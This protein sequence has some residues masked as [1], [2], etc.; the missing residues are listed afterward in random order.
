MAD[1]PAPPW[2]AVWIVEAT[3]PQRLI[4]HFAYCMC[5]LAYCGF[6]LQVHCLSV[7]QDLHLTDDAAILDL[8]QYDDVLANTWVDALQAFGAHFIAHIR[9][10]GHLRVPESEGDSIL[11]PFPD[12]SPDS[13]ASR[14]S[15]SQLD[16]LECKAKD[17]TSSKCSYSAMKSTELQLAAT[18]IVADS[19]C[20]LENVIFWIDK[21]CI[22]QQHSLKGFCIS[23][24]EEFLDRCDGMV[25]L[26][27]WEYFQRLWCVHGWAASFVRHPLENIAICMGAQHY[28]SEANFEALA[29]CSAIALIVREPLPHG[30]GPERPGRDAR[31]RAG[32]VDAALLSTPSEWLAGAAQGIQEASEFLGSRDG[33]GGA[34]APGRE[35]APAARSAATGA[36]GAAATTTKSAAEVEQDQL[37]VTTNSSDDTI[38]LGVALL[39]NVLVTAAI[40]LAVCC[41]WRAYPL[42]YSHR[43][44]EVQAL[45][46]PQDS[47]GG[48]FWASFSVTM[49]QATD[50]AG[51][52]VAMFVELCNFGMYLTAALG[53]PICVV[54]CPVYCYYGGLDSEDTLTRYSMNNIER[55]SSL[56]GFVALLVWVVVVVVHRMIWTAQEKFI[57]RRIAW[58]KA[59][60]EPRATTL[61][62]TD[63]PRQYC[64]DTGLKEYYE[65]LFPG[66]VQRVYVAKKIG[67][68]VSRAEELKSADQCLHQ[69]VHEWDKSGRRPDNRPRMLEPLSNRWTDKID[70]YTHAKVEAD[71]RLQTERDRV[72]KSMDGGDQ[73]LFASEGFV[74]FKTRRDA[75]IARQLQLEHEGQRFQ[76]SYAPDPDD[77][78]YTDLLLDSQQQR[79]LTTIG[80]GCIGF[81]YSSHFCQWSPPWHQS[82]I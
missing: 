26:L 75:E 23:M 17:V 38:K 65:K 39:F 15:V 19:G 70:F 50:V 43:S 18:E 34:G 78:R 58:L 13:A 49:E 60:P 40:L 14:A 1:A 74:T 55:D 59:M 79:V 57:P 42:V 11:D 72:Q 25:A 24:I 63:I 61:L 69:A 47:L 4:E 67:E 20:N 21:C 44:A 62:V 5:I 56:Y 12:C 48:W 76:M 54:M 37:G 32:R 73:S 36:G 27:T 53:L 28:T 41:L 31:R 30:A 33:R 81:G 82:Q 66:A 35:Q 71:A 7:Q 29:R 22:P 77:V 51:L 80:Y 46:Q 8:K 9:A 45:P 10:G 64:S 3:F 16:E 52:D 6:L 2:A 68:L